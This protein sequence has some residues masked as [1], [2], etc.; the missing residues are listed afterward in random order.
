MKKTLTRLAMQAG[1]A[2]VLAACLGSYVVAATATVADWTGDNNAPPDPGAEN[3]DYGIIITPNLSR[4]EAGG[5]FQARRTR[6][7]SGSPINSAYLSDPSLSGSSIGLPT[8]F[9]FN[10]DFSASGT[11]S[12]T[13]PNNVDPNIVFGFYA[14]TGT[15]LGNTQRLGLSF[16]DS[17]VNLFRAQSNARGSTSLAN[18]NTLTT[19][20]A[21]PSPAN[22][23]T[24]QMP[25]GTYDF[26]FSY[27]AATRQFNAS[28]TDGGTTWFRNIALPVGYAS[29]DPDRLDR[30]G[31]FQSGD[32][33][34]ASP[35]NP[36]PRYSLIVSNLS[37]SG[38]T[39]VPEPA[40]I[41]L[42]CLGL[43]FL[44]RW[45]VPR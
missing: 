44:A 16:A 20:G 38:A 12:F 45:R 5:Q 2:M 10:E 9:G 39:F 41:A 13:N 15:T 31:F 6:P 25:A 1:L 22:G 18:V 34:V 42:L 24:A 3:N 35:P 23:P 26:N 43:V 27:V 37:Y 17:G 36:Q 8:A 4:T 28:L 30:F 11:L 7:T 19:N 33:V 29:A 40:S 32:Q 21:A 14:S